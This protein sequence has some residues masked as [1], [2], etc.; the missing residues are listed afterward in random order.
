MRFRYVIF[1]FLIIC[2]TSNCSS[3]SILVKDKTYSKG[4]LIKGKKEGV[5]VY[6][7]NGY[8]YRISYYSNDK[9]DG[10]TILFDENG[11]ILRQLNFFK[12]KLNNNVYFYSNEGD[13]IA[14]YEYANDLF[15]KTIL[16]TT[17]PDAPPKGH[18]YYPLEK[19]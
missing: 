16:Q 7:K 4:D 14:I 3:P 10:K 8:V 6:Y 9:L 19:E 2:F 13:V 5:W 11:G 17:N 18:G 15:V 1:A 12:G